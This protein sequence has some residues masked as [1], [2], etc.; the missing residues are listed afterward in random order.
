[1]TT[2]HD[3]TTLRIG[4]RFEITAPLVQ[5]TGTVTPAMMDPSTGQFNP[6]RIPWIEDDTTTFMLDVLINQATSIT[7]HPQ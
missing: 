2:R 3:L 1:M 6:A 4:D 5:L 7:I